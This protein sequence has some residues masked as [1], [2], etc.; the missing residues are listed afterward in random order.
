MKKLLTGLAVLGFVSGAATAVHAADGEQVYQSAGCIACHVV[1]GKGGRV[2]PSLES[3]GEK[4]KDHIRT[5]IV[6]PSANVT[7]GYP[8]NVMPANYGDQ[9]SDEELDALVDFLAQQK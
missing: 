8:A 2:G 4:G 6:D 3:I 9:L 5:A 1:D 7:E